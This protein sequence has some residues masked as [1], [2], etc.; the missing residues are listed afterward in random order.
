MFPDSAIAQLFTL[1]YS[2]IA[3]VIKYGLGKFFFDAL[4]GDLENVPFTFKFDE[5]TTSQVK[6][7]YDAYASYWSKSENCVVNN[8]IGS[9]FVGHCFSS[10]LV[11]HYLEFKKRLNL[12]D[13]LLL[14]L[15]MDGPNVNLA[16]ERQLEA[17]MLENSNATF[18]R[19]GSCSLHPVHSAFKYGLKEL[20]F[21]FDSF[22]HDLSFFFHFQV[23]RI[24][25]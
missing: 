23:R 25:H 2:K 18:L 21:P 20:D 4:K 1:G 19:L 22:F 7:Q 14:H 16:F 12:N 9:L 3:Y 11:E 24:Y 10:D 15:G 6:K 8:Y 5:S 17:H 13:H